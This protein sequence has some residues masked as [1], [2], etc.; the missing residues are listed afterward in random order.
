VEVEWEC[1]GTSKLLR[2]TRMKGGLGRATTV[3]VG[4]SNGLAGGWGE[5]KHI[6]HC[7]INS[8]VNKFLH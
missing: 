1:K 8:V 7:I 3:K 2:N 6:F 4:G 5:F